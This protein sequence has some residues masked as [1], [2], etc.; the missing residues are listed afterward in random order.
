MDNMPVNAKVFIF[1]LP[2]VCKKKI[3]QTSL[4]SADQ[5]WMIYSKHK[6]AEDD[7]SCHAEPETRRMNSSYITHN[8]HVCKRKTFNR[9]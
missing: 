8:Y 9:V 7:L 4:V 3:P 1:H 6:I 2:P 5:G